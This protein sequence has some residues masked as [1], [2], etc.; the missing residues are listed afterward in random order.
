LD[1]PATGQPGQIL[2]DPAGPVEPLG[3]WFDVIWKQATSY[4]DTACSLPE[5]GEWESS[6]PA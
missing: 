3:Q 5:L 1:D 4:C 6:P 2:A